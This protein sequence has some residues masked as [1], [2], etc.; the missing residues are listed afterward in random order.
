MA[1]FEGIHFQNLPVRGQLYLDFLSVIF[2]ILEQKLKE[3]LNKQLNAKCFV[4]GDS[5]YWLT[6]KTEYL[7]KNW[8]I[9]CIRPR[10]L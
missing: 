6:W 2:G 5:K 1:E 9:K 8:E 3:F 4:V 10:V 7:K